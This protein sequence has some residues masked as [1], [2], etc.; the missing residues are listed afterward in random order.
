MKKTYFKKLYFNEEPVTE[1]VTVELNS[2]GTYYMST[3][4]VSQSSGFPVYTRDENVGFD[5]V[6]FLEKEGYE[7]L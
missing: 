5:A 3:T 1:Y 4:R 6:D 7:E 2:D